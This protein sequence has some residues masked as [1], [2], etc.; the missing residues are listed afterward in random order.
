MDRRNLPFRSL[1]AFEAAARHAS[2]SGAAAELGVT[3]SA[4]SHQI[5]QLEKLLGVE[6]FVR[7]NR[8]LEITLDGEMLLPVLGESFDRIASA[9]DHIGRNESDSVIEVTSTP[10][11]ATKWLVPRLADWYTDPAATRIHLRPSLDFLDFERDGI[12]LA[13]R[14][15]IPPWRGLEHSLLMP[16]HLVPV[17][18][19]AYA[20]KQGL[21]GKPGDALDHS[22]IHADI[23]DHGLGEEWRDWLGGC[24]VT[25]TGELQGLSMRDPAL[26]MQAAADGL[27]LAIGYRELIDRDLNSGALVTASDT[28]VKHQFSYYLV[29]KSRAMKNPALKGF[30]DWLVVQA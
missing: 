8:G 25:I 14:C 11:F 19:P 23:G 6:L 5:K 27:G 17:C 28:Q 10:S 30:R 15:G 3:H 26:A 7:T 2:V 18:S 12:D 1:R 9:L 13:I 4:V 21:L 20:R 22:L 24:G 29:Y 16:I